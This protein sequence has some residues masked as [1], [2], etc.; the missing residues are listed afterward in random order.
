MCVAGGT[1]DNSM[2]DTIDIIYDISASTTAK[3]SAARNG[4][5]VAKIPFNGDREAV[6]FIGGYDS[7]N[8]IYATV[9]CLYWTSE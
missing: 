6:L 8:N 9:D 2:T 3:L 7:N 1:S 4:M 5:A